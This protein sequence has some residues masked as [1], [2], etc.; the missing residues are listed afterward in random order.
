MVLNLQ[1]TNMDQELVVMKMVCASVLINYEES[2]D[3]IKVDEDYK[4]WLGNFGTSVTADLE[5][6]I[7][8]ELKRDSRQHGGAGGDDDDDDQISWNVQDNVQRLYSR[9][10]RPLMDYMYDLGTH[11]GVIV[12]AVTVGVLAVAHMSNSAILL[13]Y[14]TVIPAVTSTFDENTTGR[15][16]LL[17]GA[18]GGVT[19]MLGLPTIRNGMALAC[20]STSRGLNGLQRQLHAISQLLV[21]PL[22]TAR[23]NPIILP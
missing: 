8:L 17:M 2:D 1:K 9:Y 6:M 21:L 12:M 4:T 19:L 7:S 15:S 16:A 18:M 3:Q 13:T 22:G 20:E 5:H 14:Y 10:A 23:S 11:P